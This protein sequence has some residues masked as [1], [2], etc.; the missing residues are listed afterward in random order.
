MDNRIKIKE[1][2][3]GYHCPVNNEYKNMCSVYI[4]NEF[5]GFLMKEELFIYPKK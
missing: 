4:L 3:C 1:K 5:F 2:F